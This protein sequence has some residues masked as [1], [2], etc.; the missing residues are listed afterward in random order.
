MANEVPGFLGA[1]YIQDD[2]LP[3]TKEAMTSNLTFNKYSITDLDKKF[4]DDEQSIIVYVNDVVV[5][6][7]FTIQQCGGIINFFVPLTALDVVTVSG[8]YFSVVQGAG[9]YNFK[10]TI[11]RKEIDTSSFGIRWKQNIVVIGDWSA[12]CGKFFYDS[13]FSDKLGAK[14][15]F[16]FYADIDSNDR[17]EGYGFIKK[18]GINTDSTDVIKEDIDI[19]GTGKI[20]WAEN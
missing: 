6:T 10:I 20:Y 9:F 3:F 17:Y 11:Q 13:T 1:V 12:T 4:W 2:N 16:V 18:S 15:V 5:P 14:N 19:T 7:G 8:H